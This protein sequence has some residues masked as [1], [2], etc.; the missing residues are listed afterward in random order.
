MAIEQD[1]F[2]SADVN[3]QRQLAGGKCAGGASGAKLFD[4]AHE[5]SAAVFELGTG[6][7]DAL[8]FGE[9]FHHGQ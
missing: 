8:E 6:E 5:V 4:V 2:T 7:P 9:S 1:D 3:W